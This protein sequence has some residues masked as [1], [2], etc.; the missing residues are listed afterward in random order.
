MSDN[1]FPEDVFPDSWC[2]L[3]LVDPESLP[4]EA[5]EIHEIH[6][7]PKGWSHAG[8]RGPGGIRLHSPRLATLWHAVGRYLRDDTGLSDRVREVAILITAR[9]H[10]S[11]FEWQQHEKVARRVGV[12]QETI[13]AIKYRL[14]VA[15][16]DETDSLVIRLGRAVFG[17]HAVGPDLFRAALDRF[18]SQ[19]LIDLVSIMG[20]YAAT[21]A[22]LSLVDV[23]IPPGEEALLPVSSGG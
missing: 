8:L 21:A 4:R 17:D 3:P 11:R 1:Y 16:L 19:R 7:D 18:G 6:A 5:R 9:E 12:P 23:Q 13:E 20:T 15:S 22:M 10:D 14:P 2:R